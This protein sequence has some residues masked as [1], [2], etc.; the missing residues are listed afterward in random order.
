M[1]QVSP[2]QN[3]GHS[4]AKVS[5]FSLSLLQIPLFRHGLGEHISMMVVVVVVV[6]VVDVTSILTGVSVLDSS[7]AFSLFSILSRPENN[8]VNDH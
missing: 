5:D 2:S 8:L 4:Q 3:L 7:W 6:I 1:L